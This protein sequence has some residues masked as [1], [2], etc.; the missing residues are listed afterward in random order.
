MDLL[1]LA[2][3][4]KDLVTITYID[5]SRG[6]AV[7]G[8]N[9][10]STFTIDATIS[11][12]H[13]FE[14]EP[15]ENPVE[16]GSVN[17][18]NVKILPVKLKIEGIISNDPISLTNVAIGNLASVFGNVPGPI[19][20]G[21][22]VGANYVGSG[23]L[24]KDTGDRAKQ[25]FRKIKQLRDTK[26]TVCVTTLYSADIYKNMIIKSA[27]FPRD[28]KTGNSVKFTLNLYEIRVIGSTTTKLKTT[29]TAKGNVPKV[30]TGTI[31]ASVTERG[32][33]F[34]AG[35]TDFVSDKKKS[36]TGR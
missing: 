10:D 19:G 25:F 17:T 4:K 36:L 35:I 32:K 30:N 2:G 29:N 20:S 11:E 27:V 9:K 34:A 1:K 28:N 18:D 5:P 6:T 21:L 12:E 14:S 16:D 26:T 3:L 31:V 22:S 15:T 23:L 33:T 24:G 13:V 8:L 7:K